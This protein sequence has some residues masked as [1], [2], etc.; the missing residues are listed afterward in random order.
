MTARTY[1]LI[2]P[3]RDERANLERLVGCVMTQTVTPTA[4]IVVDNG[5]ADGT[6]ELA[7]DLESRHPWFKALTSPPTNR[8]EPGRPIVRAFRVGLA[9]LETDVDVVVKLDADVSFA[10][11][12]FEKLLEAF[13][14]DR[15]LGIAG[16]TCFEL[17]GGEWRPTHV[18]GSHVRGAVRAYRHACLADILPLEEGLGWDTIDE[19]KAAAEGWNVAVVRDLRFDHHR[20]VGGRDGKPWARAV[21]QGKAA[22]YLGYRFWYLA[23]RAAFRSRKNPAG[24][25]MVWGYLAS[26]IAREPV[27]GDPRVRDQLRRQQGLSQLSLRAREALGRRA[28]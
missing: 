15:R 1:A 16:G 10:P 2:T 25:A 27:F 24:L 4:W 11:D 7:R 21:R 14:A 22:H 8:A 3:A 23:A 26:A 17:D 5:S 12:H 28:S 13:E 6:L 19:L 20:P 9:A 18:T